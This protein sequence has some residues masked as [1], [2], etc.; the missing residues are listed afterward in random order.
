M[1]VW[2]H[3]AGYAES[4]AGQGTCLGAA[5]L[6]QPLEQPN[7]QRLWAQVFGGCGGHRFMHCPGTGP[8]DKGARAGDLQ[9][10]AVDARAA[11]SICARGRSLGRTWE[12][13]WAEHT[14]DARSQSRAG[15]RGTRGASLWN[16]DR[17]MKGPRAR[18]LAVPGRA[19]CPC[20]THGAENGLSIPASEPHVWKRVAM[21]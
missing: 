6:W 9:G 11:H 17:Y 5:G 15:C 20:S 2:G 12:L 21:T 18:G 3:G 19:V 1:Q 4:A 16:G 8:G 13:V 14:V 10:E 7:G